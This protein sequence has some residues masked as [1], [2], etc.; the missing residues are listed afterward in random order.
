MFQIL[1]TWVMM[2]LVPPITCPPTLMG[3]WVTMIGD[4]C[5]ATVTVPALGVTGL[6]PAMPVGVPM[7]AIPAGLMAPG[8]RTRV[9]GV[10]GVT[11]LGVGVTVGVAVGGTAGVGG[12]SYFCTCS[13]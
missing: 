9:V 5:L 7:V 13:K 3:C 8:A 4:F 1:G 12:M 10:A 11:A 6:I 2:V